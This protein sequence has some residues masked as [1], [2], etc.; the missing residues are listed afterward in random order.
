[1]F[2]TKTKDGTTLLEGGA[3]TLA[4]AINIFQPV[5][6]VLIT[7][8]NV[9]PGTRFPETTWVAFGAGR[10]VVGVGSNGVNSYAAE[11]AFGVD[12]VTLSAAQSGVNSHVH[13]DTLA[14]PAHTHSGPS[15]EHSLD[16]NTLVGANPSGTGY[17]FAVSIGGTFNNLGID[18]QG[19]TDAGGTGGTGGASATTL[20]G[21]VGAISGA[22]AAASHENRQ[23]SI[24]TYLWKRT[25]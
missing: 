9:N 16:F 23:A 21:S 4:S 13:V 24:A 17:N 3:L 11:Q 14:A 6:S 1:M 7:T 22:S 19:S 2:R 20:T 10:A 8:T 25:V 5:G 18:Q 12:S 15:H